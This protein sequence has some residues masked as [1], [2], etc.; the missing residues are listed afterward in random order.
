MRP[1]KDDKY[2]GD[3]TKLEAAYL[4]SLQP[5]AVTPS[6][7]TINGNSIVGSG[8]IVITPDKHYMHIQGSASTVWVIP[9]NLN[10]YPSVRVFTGFGDEVVGDV[11]YDSVN[12][13]TITF[14]AVFAGRAFLN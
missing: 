7:K 1:P 8:D 14:S 2:L 11:V 6:V 5:H 3:N 4:H 10:K 9:H 13:V 12:Q